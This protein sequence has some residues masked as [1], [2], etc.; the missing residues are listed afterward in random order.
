MLHNVVFSDNIFLLSRTLSLVLESLQ[1]N[2]SDALF[3][4]KLESD[5]VFSAEV[6]KRVYEKLNSQEHLH[7]Y[8]DSMK[9]LYACSL[10]FLMILSEVTTS[11]KNL[12]LKSPNMI[13][14]LKKQHE[15]IRE[16]ISK[17]IHNTDV[18]AEIINMVSDLEMNELL[19]F[20]NENI[21]SK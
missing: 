8:L 20:K 3:S 2:F 4:K 1:L 7:D 18:D 10:K 21:S 16:N 6:I 15:E 11:E 17:K 5:I 13:N 19:N 14:K 12:F 9:C